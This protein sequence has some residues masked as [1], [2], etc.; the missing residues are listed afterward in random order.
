[1]YRLTVAVVVVLAVVVIALEQTKQISKQLCFLT[2]S[3]WFYIWL[4]FRP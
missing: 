2:D 4:I 1:M 3:Y